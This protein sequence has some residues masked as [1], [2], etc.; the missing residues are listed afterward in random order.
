MLCYVPDLSKIAIVYFFSIVPFNL[1]FVVTSKIKLI[2]FDCSHFECPKFNMYPGHLE[3][4]LDFGH[5]LLIFLIL[6][7]FWLSETGQICDFWAFS[8]EHKGGMAS[9]LHVD[10]F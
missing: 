2:I 3:N 5:R 10:V 1:V 7:A 6:A 9:N 4:W 8:W